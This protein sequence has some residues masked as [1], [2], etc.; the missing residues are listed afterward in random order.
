MNIARIVGAA[1]GGAVAAALGLAA[2]FGLNALSFVAVL[3]SLMVMSGAQIARPVRAPR[4]RGQ[5]RA[6]FRYVR[7]TPELLLPLVMIAIIG[8]L[9]W[10]FQV[11]LPLV[12]NETFHGGAGLY[13]AMTATM[14]I[15]AVIGGLVSASRPRVGM[16]TLG[17]AAIGW[18]IA[19]TAAG[20]APTLP[21]E[22][23]VLACVGYG[24]ITFN[25]YAKTALQVAAS[26]EMRGR[27]MALWGLAWL[28]STPIGGPVI[29]WIGEAFGG[30]WT[31]LAGGIPTLVVGLAALPTLS[32]LDRRSGDPVSA[33]AYPGG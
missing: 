21:I 15:G 9:A 23:A 27:V 20:L 10:E 24:S 22:F 29:G 11:S 4:E 13:G 19:I 25:S 18:G 26:P 2:C 12:A 16:R 6:G 1:V 14:G 28:G 7:T 8:T 5:L 17:I 33:V 31:L 32:R 30:R 3:V